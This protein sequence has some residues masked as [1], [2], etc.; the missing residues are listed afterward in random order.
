MILATLTCVWD[1]PANATHNAGS[2]C[3]RV[4]QRR[5]GRLSIRDNRGKLAL[6]RQGATGLSD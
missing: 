5:A 2:I 6:A 3:H 1:P 4:W